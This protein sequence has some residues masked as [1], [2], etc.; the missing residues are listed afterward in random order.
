MG[1]MGRRWPCCMWS[2]KNPRGKRRNVKPEI[3]EK[4]HI[5]CFLRPGQ[6][7]CIS[8]LNQLF[9][10][11]WYGP[12]AVEEAFHPFLVDVWSV[13]RVIHSLFLYLIGNDQVEFVENLTEKIMMIDDPL[14]RPS[15]QDAVQ[16]VVAYTTNTTRPPE[17]RLDTC[18][19]SDNDTDNESSDLFKTP[20]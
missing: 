6:F 20:F 1:S 18:D 3:I 2:G 10:L 11:L 12:R 16:E 9:T 8:A 7:Q 5:S 17:K 14:T 4:S 15:I 13:G 19:V